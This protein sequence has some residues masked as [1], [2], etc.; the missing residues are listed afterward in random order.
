MFLIVCH[1]FVSVKI[2]TAINLI[3]TVFISVLLIWGVV[4]VRTFVFTYRKNSFTPTEVSYNALL[5]SR[6]QIAPSH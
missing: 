6:L 4:K 1:I 3:M 2:I 5:T